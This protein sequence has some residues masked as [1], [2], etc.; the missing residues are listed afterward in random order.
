MDKKTRAK[1]LADKFMD[2]KSFPDL[3]A[4]GKFTHTVDDLR[5]ALGSCLNF[6][7]LYPELFEEFMKYIMPL[8]LAEADS[9]R[10]QYVYVLVAETLKNA[11]KTV[12]CYEEDH[13]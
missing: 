4:I 6:A 3:I 8:I 1:L 10:Q 2:G 5:I 11:K 12:N 7:E 13:A 9:G